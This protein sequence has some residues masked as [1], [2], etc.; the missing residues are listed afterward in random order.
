MLPALIRDGREPIQ[1]KFIYHGQDETPHV[2]WRDIIIIP[3]AHPRQ[4]IYHIEVLEHN[5]DRYIFELYA[6]VLIDYNGFSTE[7]PRHLSVVKSARRYHFESFGGFVMPQDERNVRR[8]SWLNDIGL[9][10]LWPNKYNTSIQRYFSTTRKPLYTSDSVLAIS[11]EMIFARVENEW[12]QF[13]SERII[14]PHVLEE[15]KM[16]SSIL[17]L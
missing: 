7:H 12:V 5:A 15:V 8:P 13:P 17:S 16:V 10:D 11:P 1:V 2:R 4:Y 14:E 3:T 6:A 9:A